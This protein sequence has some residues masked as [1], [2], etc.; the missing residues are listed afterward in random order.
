MTFSSM[1]AG[2]NPLTEPIGIY[3][4]Q[5]LLVIFISRLVYIPLSYLKQPRI[6]AEVITGIVLGQ[7][8]LCRVPAFASNLFPPSSFKILSST[9]NFGLVFYMFLVGLELDP[10]LILKNF[11]RAFPISA[12]G[13]ALP[14]FASIG[15]SALLYNEYADSGAVAFP[16]FFTFVAAAMSLTTYPSI[17]RIVTE[18][19][20]QTTPLGQTTLAV[21]AVNDI[22][23]WIFLL[24]V[25]GLINNTANTAV[26]AYIFLAM[27]LYTLFLWFAVRPFLGRLV[28]LSGSSDSLSQ[29]LIFLTLMCVLISAFFTQAIGASSIFGAFLVGVIVPHDHSFAVNLVEKLEDIMDICFMPLYF[30]TLGFYARID[31]LTS[32][33]DWGMI[34]LFVAVSGL[35][36]ILGHTLAAKFMNNFTWKESF[37]IGAIL[38]SRGFLEFIILNLG[39]H[40]NIISAKVFTILLI[41]VLISDIITGPIAS[42]ICPSNNA[43]I[44][45]AD[46][47]FTVKTSLLEEPLTSKVGGSLKLVL[48]FEATFS[49]NLNIL[50][51]LPNMQSVPGTMALTDYFKSSQL[52]L[53]VTSLRLIRLSDR[54][55]SVMMATTDTSD[56]LRHDPVTSIFRSFGMLN[57]I[58]TA[59]RL[60]IAP[61]EEFAEQIVHSAGHCN[62]II[63]PWSV[64]PSG[65][66]LPNNH[67]LGEGLTVHGA[68][69]LESGG[70]GGGTG[71]P[72]DIA[73]QALDSVPIDEGLR[74]PLIEGVQKLATC[75]VAVF[76]D[77]GFGR[78]AIA[79]FKT[80]GALAFSHVTTA[81]VIGNSHA[82]L[83]VLPEDAPVGNSKKSAPS[84]ESTR[85][86]L[87]FFGKMQDCI[88]AL[89]L[90]THLSRRKNVHLFV[91]HVV[92]AVADAADDR[93]ALYLER[94]RAHLVK[95]NGSNSQF[96]FETITTGAPVAALSEKVKA[97]L[98]DGRDL[99]V[100]GASIYQQA[101]EFR[102]WVDKE[103]TASVLTVQKRGDGAVEH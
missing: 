60:G 42:F 93:D 16:P 37:T 78:V 23:S 85:I 15:A 34:V 17:A 102:E 68:G 53:S 98:R 10:R 41:V 25:I 56:T 40:A 36:K 76:L 50:C 31:L 79:P 65:S 101:Y 89:K 12:A 67:S 48:P 2:E 75:N 71:N 21:A 28:D 59:S 94:V 24:F 4:M 1:I 47:D 90:T 80:D 30:F 77:R 88:E 103:V 13:S 96:Q 9:A 82:T 62:L 14:F 72:V 63:L 61:I 11:S 58:K 95:Q 45:K 7:S 26:A 43:A 83:A 92:R 52:E 81:E 29:M 5:V 91:V 3:L 70:V 8:G 74:G 64:A 54:T 38:N 32:G 73:V 84:H 20:L 99:L 27:I 35:T 57:G 33:M 97:F 51:Y 55:S 66:F 44:T 46:T 18:K 87:P 49:R 100:L 69:L 39:L 22:G 86:F 19:K 6:V